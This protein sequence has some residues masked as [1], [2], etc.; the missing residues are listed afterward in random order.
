[1]NKGLK[2][3]ISLAV[4]YLLHAAPAHSAQISGPTLTHSDDRVLVST[5]LEIDESYRTE[6]KKGISKNIVIYIDLFRRW[7]NWP[8]EFV[9]GQRYEQTLKCDPV[10]REYKAS[11]LHGARILER[12]FSDCD[13]MIQWALRVDE[14]TLSGIRE[15]PEGQYLVR[16]TVESRLGRLPPFIN[17]LFFFVREIEFR[18]QQSSEPFEH[19]SK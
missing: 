9:Q 14:A 8:D 11:S 12:R 17:L 1:M 5:A 7:D 18:L 19:L 4:V 2:L 10:K 6:I 13:A 3:A 15:L 16:V